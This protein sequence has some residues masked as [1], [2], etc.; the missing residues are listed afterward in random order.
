LKQ[1]R[2]ATTLILLLGPI[3]YLA[4]HWNALPATLPSHYDIH[5][6]ANRHAPKEILWVFVAISIFMYAVMLIPSR[7]PQLFNLPVPPDDPACPRAVA[8]AIDMLGWIRLEIAAMFAFLI[9][10]TVH[11][12]IAH[13]TDLGWP[14]LPL[15]TLVVAVTTVIF[16]VRMKALLKP[17]S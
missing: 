6:V 8:L 14:F 11:I 3:P 17:A 4:L 1:L 10:Q 7:F 13:S 9:A 15:S 5:G 12:G 16:L 2:E